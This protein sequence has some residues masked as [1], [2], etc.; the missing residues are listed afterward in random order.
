MIYIVLVLISF[1]LTY[2]IKNYMIKKSFVASINE[3]SSHTVPTPHGGG[4]AIAITWFIGLFYLYFIGQIENNLFYALLFGAVISIVSFFDDIY[5]LSPK[6]RLI[7][8]AIVAIGGLYFLGG[9]ETLTFGIFDIQNSIFTN[10]FAFFMIIWF[11]NL[12]NFLDGINGYAGSEAV[13]LSLAGFILFGGNHFLVLAV[14]VLGFLYWN[15]NKAKIF[16]GD[17][18]STL[19]G[20]NVAIFTIYYANQEPTNF[21]IWI[22]LFSVYW[23][24]ATLT[25]IRRKLNKERLSQAHKK[26]AYQ[27]LTQAGWSHYKVTNYSIVLNILLF[28]IVYFISNIFVAFLFSFVVLV[29]VMKFIDSKKAFE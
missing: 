23:F 26:H 3:R 16:M 22:I 24:D 13:F 10:I 11:I 18:G 7:I 21:W 17:V 27:R 1:F 20:Y 19:L 12:Y 25:L 28:A 4:I 8:Q 14:A 6:S 29:L 15:W 9:F 2:F 5:E